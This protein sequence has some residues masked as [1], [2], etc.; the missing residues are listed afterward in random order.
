MFTKSTGTRA[1]RGHLQHGNRT[2]VIVE[3]GFIGYAMDNGQPVLLPPGLHVW[4][5]ESLYFIQSVSK[6]RD[7]IVWLATRM[8]A[9]VHSCAARR[10]E[11]KAAIC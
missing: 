6:R 8:H 3:Q 9:K 4:T 5:S 11:R 2:I 7:E 1:I 10:Q